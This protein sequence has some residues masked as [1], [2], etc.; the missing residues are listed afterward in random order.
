M[1]AHPLHDE[2]IWRRTGPI[3]DGRPPVLVT[4]FRTERD[5]PRIVAYVAWFDH[6]VTSLGYYPGRDEPPNA[7]VRGPMM[8]PYGQRG[9][10]PGHLQ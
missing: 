8:V 9:R 3:L 10:L 7:P 2:G 1:F 6:T 4:T 5:F